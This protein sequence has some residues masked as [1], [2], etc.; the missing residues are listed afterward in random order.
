VGINRYQRT[1]AAVR[2]R[3]LAEFPDARPGEG[4]TDDVSHTLWMIGQ[5]SQMTDQ[6]RIDRWAGWIC[7]KAHSLGVID[8]GDDKLSEI[9]ALAREDLAR[10]SSRYSINTNP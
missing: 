7:A 4:A 5:I 1:L 10:D 6:G 8:S 9:R 2:R 3:L